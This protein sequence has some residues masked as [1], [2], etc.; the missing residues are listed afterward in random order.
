MQDRCAD[1]AHA[2]KSHKDIVSN[3]RVAAAI[4]AVP[5]DVVIKNLSFSVR[6]HLHL[7]IVWCLLLYR[8]HSP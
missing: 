6:S 1:I 3:S 2:I 4:D 5:E 7:G 8:I